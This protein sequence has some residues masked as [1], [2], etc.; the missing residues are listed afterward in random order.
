MREII[1]ALKLDIVKRN[2]VCVNLDNLTHT[3]VYC[4]KGDEKYIFT[5]PIKGTYRHNLHQVIKKE[6][7][8]YQKVRSTNS[9]VSDIDIRDWEILWQS[10]IERQYGIRGMYGCRRIPNENGV[11]IKNTFWGEDYYVA[12]IEDNQNNNNLLERN[13]T[14]IEEALC[15]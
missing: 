10:S 15:L 9:R 14:N 13:I 1:E 8:N 5:A 7:L 11:V 4:N 3:N 12:V 6:G 2:W